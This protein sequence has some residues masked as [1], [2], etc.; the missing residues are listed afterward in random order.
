MCGRY[1]ILPSAEAWANVLE[2]FGEAIFNQLRAM[3]PRNDVRPSTLVPVVYW[4]KEE[5]APKLEMMRWG[6]V[7]HFW[8]ADQPQAP[9]H[10]HN[11]RIESMPNGGMWKHPIRYARA[12]MP[13]SSWIEWQKQL[14]PETGE[15]MKNPQTRRPLTVPHAMRPENGEFFFAA[16]YAVN[17]Q[18]RPGLVTKS[19][20]II[21]MEPVN[22]ALRAVH[23][24]MPAI[25]KPAAFKEWLDPEQ[26]DP[27]QALDL[28]RTQ[29]ET[30]YTIFPSAY[31]T[32]SEQTV[33]Q[34]VIP[35]EPKSPAP[36]KSLVPKK[37]KPGSNQGDLF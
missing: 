35:P 13:G 27:E 31:T 15:E 19:C 17:D 21:T 22:E 7:P 30:E 24:R 1:N 34:R 23:T 9:E 11:A 18:W 20:A 16:L 3:E 29:H 33:L 6:F 32:P 14:D 28:L 12:L 26:T 25:L 37:T 8:R 5:S 10:T 4:S 36:K 2:S